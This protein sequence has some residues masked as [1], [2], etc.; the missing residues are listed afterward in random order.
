MAATLIGKD[1]DEDQRAGRRITFPASQ[2]DEPYRYA[3]GR[4]S[5]QPR[6]QVRGLGVVFQEFTGPL[7]RTVPAEHQRVGPV[8][9][10]G[11]APSDD[12]NERSPADPRHRLQPH[13]RGLGQAS[14]RIRP[15]EPLF[16]LKQPESAGFG[17]TAPTRVVRLHGGIDQEVNRRSRRRGPRSRGHDRTCGI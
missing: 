14:A 7:L 2:S 16:L 1:T 3:V 6:I 17:D 12:R 8:K 11:Q 13:A 9:G 10:S 5:V 15:P 4:V